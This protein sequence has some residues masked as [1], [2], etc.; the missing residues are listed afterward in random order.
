MISWTFTFYNNVALTATIYL[1]YY[2]L[3]VCQRFKTSDTTFETHM[4]MVFDF[5]T[6]VLSKGE[7]S[8]EG[9]SELPPKLTAPSSER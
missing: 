8:A 9:K 2:I 1:V 4:R 7:C 5:R 3:Y 6:C